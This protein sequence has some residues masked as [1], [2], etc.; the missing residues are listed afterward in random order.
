MKQFRATARASGV[1]LTT[2]VFPENTNLAIKVL[3]AQFG[4]NNI[5][6]IHAQIGGC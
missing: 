1:I 5:M 3:Q 2:V 6:S 4:A